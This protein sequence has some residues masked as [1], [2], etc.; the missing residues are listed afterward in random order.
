MTGVGGIADAAAGATDAPRSQ[1][2]LNAVSVTRRVVSRGE[3]NG[4][5]R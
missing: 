2:E 3:Y 5:I 4:R 1:L